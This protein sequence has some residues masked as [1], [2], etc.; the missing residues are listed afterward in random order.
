MD[1]LGSLREVLSAGG[2]EEP[3]RGGFQVV[4][5]VAGECEISPEQVLQ[6]AYCLQSPLYHY[7][8]PSLL[9]LSLPV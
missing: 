9:S 3:V 5:D 2:G 8:V 7:I 4:W 1:A 6:R